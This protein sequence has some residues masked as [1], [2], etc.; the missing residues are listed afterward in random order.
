MPLYGVPGRLVI[1]RDG[2]TSSRRD[3]IREYELFVHGRRQ[4]QQAT[5]VDDEWK[6]MKYDH[7]A[8]QSL[9]VTLDCPNEYDAH[10]H[11]Q[12][13]NGGAEGFCCV[14]STAEKHTS[15]C[16]ISKKLHRPA[17]A[18]SHR[19]RFRTTRIPPN[20]RTRAPPPDIPRETLGSVFCYIPSMIGPSRGVLPF[21]SR[22]I[23][24]HRARHCFVARTAPQQEDGLRGPE[25]PAPQ[26][27]DQV[28]RQ[29]S[30]DSDPASYTARLTY[31]LRFARRSAN[32]CYKLQRI[33][34][35]RGPD[36]RG[37]TLT[38]AGTRQTAAEVT[39][40]LT[41][42]RG[43]ALAQLHPALEKG[44][45]ELR[46][47]VFIFE[48]KNEG[49]PR[50]FKENKVRFRKLSQPTTSSGTRPTRTRSN[51]LQR[52]QPDFNEP[53]RA[54]PRDSA[55]SA[56][57]PA[58]GPQPLTGP[59][60]TR[61]AHLIS[62]RRSFGKGRRTATPRARKSLP[63][64][65]APPI[66]KPLEVESSREARTHRSEW[67]HGRRV[68]TSGPFGSHESACRSVKE[69]ARTGCKPKATR[70]LVQLPP[71]ALPVQR[72]SDERV[73]ISSGRRAARSTADVLGQILKREQTAPASQTTTHGSR[74]AGKP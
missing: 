52:P 37:W 63:Q 66:S 1:W 3:T 23:G 10:E 58:C 67:R 26:A 20:A 71:H 45:L 39:P 15:A 50:F 11:D 42:A 61:I 19:H 18:G 34:L 14:E 54:P 22:R 12:E 30:E 47:F 48:K 44:F 59:Y 55:R 27:T 9:R 49:S 57:A 7:G 43:T 68:G 31:P 36:Q 21:K 60:R 73:E 28:P 13:L 51:D 46:I 2:Q 5:R 72:Y 6:L 41:T 62:G 29:T 16:M 74:H 8:P 40:A 38:D 4:G 64:A 35:E 32:D 33:G 53:T 24:L 70:S 25:Q 65:L 69:A 56:T 17:G